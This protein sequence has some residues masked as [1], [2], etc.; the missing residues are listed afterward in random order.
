[1]DAAD[2]S[3]D[4]TRCAALCCVTPAFDRSPEFAFDKP[5]GVACRNLDSKNRCRIHDRLEKEGFLGCVLFDCFGAGQR[6]TQELFAG[7][8]W[9]DEPDLLPEMSLC[10][11]VLR[12]VHE[13][14]ALLN[15][16]AKSPLRPPELKALAELE[17]SLDPVGGWSIE[18]LRELEIDALE[19]RVRRWLITLRD[20]FAAPS[21]GAGSTPPR[22]RA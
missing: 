3:P 20:H 9:R 22:G 5:A 11:S 21:P 4:C 18:R 10:F 6:V 14:M 2:L 13:L 17:R 16:A 7:R 19:G 15:E 1:M 8:S 12:R